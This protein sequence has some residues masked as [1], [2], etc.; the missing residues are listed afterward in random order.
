[1]ERHGGG[2]GG[3]GSGGGGG[4]KGGGTP[5]VGVPDGPGLRG[6]QV[7]LQQRLRK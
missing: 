1:M 6:K 7:E 4:G 5:S 2:G 3:G